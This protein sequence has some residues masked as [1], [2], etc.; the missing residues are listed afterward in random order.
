M[1]NEILKWLKIIRLGTLIISFCPVI[2]GIIVASKYA[3]INWLI[4]IITIICAMSLQAIS[5]MIN[6]FFD[7]KNGIDTHQ[8]SGYEKPL[9]AGILTIKEQKR[10][11]AIV[12]AFSTILGIILILKGGLP[13]AIIGLFAL[14][15]AWFYTATR[16]SLS[17]L[18]LGDIFVFLLFGPIATIGT[19]YLQIRE[20]NIESMWAGLV[21]GAIA[22]GVLIVNNIRDKETDSLAK[23]KSFAVRFGKRATEIEY[24]IFIFSTFAFSYIYYGW[25]I[26]NIVTI[27]GLILFFMLIKAKGEKYNIVLVL[28]SMLNVIFIMLLVL[29]IIIDE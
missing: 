5:N 24:L 1:K 11:I 14:L 21:C 26:I 28:T 27:F 25:S 29:N 12:F 2:V 20:F 18:G 9:V 19:V 6:D 10:N 15:S 4:A 3:E 8:Y 16:K 23:R 17:H 22:T 7:F 13:I